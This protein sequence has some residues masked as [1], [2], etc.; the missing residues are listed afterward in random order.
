[1][2]YV[3]PPAFA[4]PDDVIGQALNKRRNGICASIAVPAR[5]PVPKWRTRSSGAPREIPF[6]SKATAC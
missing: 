6:A 5:C 2:R 4:K 1:M 3:G